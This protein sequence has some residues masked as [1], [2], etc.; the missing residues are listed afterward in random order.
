M[1]WFESSR[2]HQT[3]AWH[4]MRGFFH[5]NR[6][7]AGLNKVQWKKTRTAKA[8]GFGLYSEKT[9]FGSWSNPVVGTDA[10]P[11]ASTCTKPKPGMQCGAFF[12]LIRYKLA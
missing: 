5:F 7:Q 9:F 3:K 4:A 8:S 10:R 6:L 11:S 2:G 12:I 1:C